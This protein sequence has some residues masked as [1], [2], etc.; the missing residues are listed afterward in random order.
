MRILVVGPG[1]IGSTFAFHLARAGHAVSVLARGKRL[2]QLERDP[3][4]ITQ[5]GERAPVD[6]V[7][8]DRAS[9]G[10][11][12]RRAICVRLSWRRVYAARRWR[13]S[14]AGAKRHDSERIAV[15]PAVLT[16]WYPHSRG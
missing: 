6:V 11:G 5:R 8:V 7:R 13:D 12:R 16:E 9:S 1:A 3:A 14:S 2:A 4:I 15:G 10:S